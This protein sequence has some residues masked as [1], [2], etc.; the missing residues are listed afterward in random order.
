MFVFLINVGKMSLKILCRSN[1]I[2]QVVIVLLAILIKTTWNETLVATESPQKKP[3]VCPKTV[4]N[5][6]EPPVL[7]GVPLVRSQGEAMLDCRGL[8]LGD[9]AI[10]KILN[11]YLYN[12]SL[13]P[14][15]GL[16][17]SENN[18]VRNYFLFFKVYFLTILSILTDKCP[19]SN[20]IF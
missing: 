8:N 18:L 15:G 19:L 5:C 1:F 2:L 14:L 17:L 13:S 4:C 10:S 12:S 9:V 7:S 11:N 20:C 3:L 6:S 16:D